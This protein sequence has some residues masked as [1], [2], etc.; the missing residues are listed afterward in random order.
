MSFWS[1]PKPAEPV[2]TPSDAARIL[3]QLAAAQRARRMATTDMLRAFVAAGGV[4]Q[5]GWKHV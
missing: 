1:R 5:L 3:S 2:V 4:S